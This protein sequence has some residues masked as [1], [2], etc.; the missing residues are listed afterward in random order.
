M[1]LHD[2]IFRGRIELLRKTLQT[3]FIPS[4]PQISQHKESLYSNMVFISKNS[5][6]LHLGEISQHLK[7]G[8]ERV[9]QSWKGF[10]IPR[11]QLWQPPAGWS[12]GL[13]WHWP[14]SQGGRSVEWPCE[15]GSGTTQDG[16]F[17]ASGNVSFLWGNGQCRILT[18]MALILS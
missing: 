14:S 17:P 6:H 12:A 8:K 16:G 13:T 10:R 15:R 11:H 18:W 9:V 1:F 3:F 4:S 2:S 5:S 7:K